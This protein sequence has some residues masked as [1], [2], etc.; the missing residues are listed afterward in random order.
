V[1]WID[2]QQRGPV[3]RVRRGQMVR[4][5]RCVFEGQARRYRI[6]EHPPLAIAT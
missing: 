1:D 6:G 5:A 2:A 4:F 3:L